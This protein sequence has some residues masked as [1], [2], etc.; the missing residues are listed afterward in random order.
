MNTKPQSSKDITFLNE[1][2]QVACGGGMFVN[3]TRSS[4]GTL[5]RAYYF[6]WTAADRSRPELKIADC[7]DMAFTRAA[8]IATE[9]RLLIRAGGD[10]RR[11]RA[12]TG[13][14]FQA[15][16]ESHTADW[17]KNKNPMEEY[18]WKRLPSQVPTL[19]DRALASIT[20]DDMV[21]A[22]TP[23]FDRIPAS[24]DRV[25]WRIET[26]FNLAKVKKQFFGDNPAAWSLLKHIPAIASDKKRA[27]KERVHHA[28]LPWQQLPELMRKLQSENRVAARCLEVAILTCARA[29]E[30]RLMQWSEIDFDK[31][32][33]TVPAI[34]M[35]ARKEHIVP[36]SRQAIAIIK[37]MPKSKDY[38]FTS[39]KM[40]DADEA[41]TARTLLRI[42]TELAGVT[43]H[44]FRATFRN[45]GGETNAEEYQ[46]LEYCLAHVVGDEAAR[47]YLT[48]SVIE[49]RRAVMQAWA[50]YA[51][52]PSNV[53]RM[54]MVA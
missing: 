2:G 35:K 8:K 34:R 29:K 23:L 9:W 37:A 54:G 17:C 49:R 47:A 13:I 52:P 4:D 26:V 32:T 46:T 22:L 50:D 51:L 24:A 33:W 3:V 11:I 30:I 10:P 44:G 53:V 25:R 40:F 48:S 18:L 42:A 16:V 20:L 19:A 45:W 27:S 38:V 36:L 28:S 21:E 39:E 5:H 43:Q 6:R 12:A 14:T 41:V 7:A 15:F 31:A 1:V